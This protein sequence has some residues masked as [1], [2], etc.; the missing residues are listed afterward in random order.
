MSNV[1][2]LDEAINKIFD[3]RD[4]YLSLND[5]DRAKIRV[6]KQRFLSKTLSL[7]SKISLA[8]KYGAEVTVDVQVKFK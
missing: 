1:Y 2:T 5:I 6:Y 4:Y 7:D 8:K 3:D